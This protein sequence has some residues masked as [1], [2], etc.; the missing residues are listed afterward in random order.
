MADLTRIAQRLEAMQTKNEELR[1]Q[2]E[3]RGTEKAEMVARHNAE[4]TAHNAETEALTKRRQEL[5]DDY[6]EL[7]PVFDALNQ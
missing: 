4:V 5:K 7:K 3:T 6:G 2:L 1:E